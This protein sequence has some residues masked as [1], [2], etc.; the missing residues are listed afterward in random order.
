MDTLPTMECEGPELVRDLD[1]L[2]EFQHPRTTEH[3][4][5]ATV[6]PNA[7]DDASILRDVCH[8]HPREMEYCRG[9]YISNT[10]CV[11]R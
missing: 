5:A 11:R 2:N 1:E 4:V 7:N 8:E 10:D 6:A 3:D 9:L